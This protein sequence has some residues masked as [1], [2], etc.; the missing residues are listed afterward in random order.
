MFIRTE[1]SV[2]EFF[3]LYPL[4]SIL[5]IVNICMWGIID[6]FHLEIGNAIYQWGVGHNIS[7]YSGEYQRLI[8][9]IFL[10]AGAGHMLFNSFALVIFGPALERM[11]GKFTFLLIYLGTGIAGNIGTYVVAPTSL[12][13]HLGASGAIYGLL[14]IYMYMSIFRKDLIDQ[15]NAQI[16]RTIFII[17]LVMTFIQ[18]NIN[19]PAHIFGFLAGFAIGPI[20][21]RK[22]RPFIVPR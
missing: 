15:Q 12:T 11:V 17:G 19:I 3:R 9:P 5:I 1:K 4:V 20:G 16:A 8:I 22:A 13:T 10:H 6:L 2:G 21:L 7:V 14:G 18:P